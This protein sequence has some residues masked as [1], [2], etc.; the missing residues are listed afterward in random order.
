MDLP[1]EEHRAVAELMRQTGMSAIEIARRTGVPSR[2]IS[3]WNRRYGWRE[4]ASVAKRRLDPGTWA[5]A[6]RLAVERIH[7][8]PEVEAAT[9]AVALGGTVHGA[10][11][12]FRTCGFPPKRRVRPGVPSPPDDAPGSAA[13]S[14]VELDHALRDHIGRQIARFDEALSADP[15]P[16]LDSARVLRDL[17]GLKRLL[18]DLFSDERERIHAT[19]RS[20]AGHDDDGAA[21]DLPALRAAIAARYAAGLG[22]RPDAGIPGEPAAAPDPGAGLGLAP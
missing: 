17:G 12:L 22:E 2:R 11:S 21:A 14:T 20:P 3:D 16:A 5:P 9:L 10:A 8:I 7:A 4:T 13:M 19:S 1:S 6:R 15:P 18:D